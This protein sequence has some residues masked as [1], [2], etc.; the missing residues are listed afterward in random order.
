MIGGAEF[1]ISERDGAAIA[2]GTDIASS[3]AGFR[4]AAGFRF[5]VA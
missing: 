2:A 1:D 3:K 4:G 5:G